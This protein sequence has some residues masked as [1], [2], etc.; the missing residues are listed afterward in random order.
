MW[1]G[2]VLNFMYF[3]FHA[4]PSVPTGTILKVSH[5]PALQQSRQTAEHTS[6]I[7]EEVKET[8]VQ[9]NNLTTDDLATVDMD[10]DSSISSSSGTCSSISESGQLSL[11]NLSTLL[12]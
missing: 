10:L 8:A 5:R 1:P 6:V 7:T 9:A 2:R 4:D 12:S 3:Y 11:Q